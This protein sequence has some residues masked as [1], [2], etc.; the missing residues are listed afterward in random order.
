MHRSILYILG[1]LLIFSN[2]LIAEEVSSYSI[3]KEQRKFESHST[4]APY[5]MKDAAKYH[6][7]LNYREKSFFPPLEDCKLYLIL[8]QEERAEL[9]ITMDNETAE[10]TLPVSEEKQILT[11][12][13]PEGTSVR[14]LSMPLV[15]EYSLTPYKSPGSETEITVN[16]DRPDEYLLSLPGINPEGKELSVILDNRDILNIQ[17]KDGEMYRLEAFEGSRSFHFPFPEDNS[18]TLTLSSPT[19]LNSLSFQAVDVP[20]FPNP[21]VRSG[22]QILY[23]SLSTWRNEEFEIY[24]WSSFPE[25][26]IMDCLDYDVQNRFFRRLAFFVEKK[27]YKG[28]LL[29]NAEL[30]GKHAWNA[31]DYRAYDL[32]EFFN[33]VA[34]RNFTIYPEEALLRNLLISRGILIQDEDGA[35]YPGQGAVLSISRESSDALR[36][37]FFVHESSHGIYFISFEYREFVRTLWES[38][39]EEDREMWRFFLGWYGYDPEEEDLMIN[40]F[41]AYLMQQSSD[42]APGYFGP[43]MSS[44]AGKYPAQRMLLERGIGADSA[45]FQIWAEVLE[46]WLAEKW[47]LKAGNFFPL[48]KELH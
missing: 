40:E 3:R 14:S 32:A 23:R 11:L 22:N 4:A 27:G 47:G 15:Q 5:L 7:G 25:I 17:N 6:P 36:Y 38:L 28:T 33:L 9:T 45:G 16:L 35:L 20:D 13:I 41:Q 8:P 42:E 26:L 12:I 37:R 19:G 21:I 30:K 18:A 43:R 29:S 2:S 39:H 10:L 34:Q 48:Y 31:H 46:D 44:L 24:S 1:I